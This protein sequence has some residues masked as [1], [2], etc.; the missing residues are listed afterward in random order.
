[1]VLSIWGSGLNGLSP[2][3][4]DLVLTLLTVCPSPISFPGNVAPR[5]SLSSPE[6][7]WE[8]PRIL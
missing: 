3:S 2:F 1:M 5:F 6:R 7:G 4:Y 8:R